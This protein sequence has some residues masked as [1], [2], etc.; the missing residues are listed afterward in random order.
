MKKKILIPVIAGVLIIIGVVLFLILRSGEDSYF[1]IRILYSEGN[2]NIKRDGNSFKASKDMTL[3]DKDYVTVGSDGF[4]RIDCD[5]KTYAHFEHDTEAT[6]KANSNKKLTINMVKG[7]LVIDVQKK[8]DD[9]EKLNIVTPNTTMAIRG[10]VVAVRTYPTEDGG[11]RTINYCLEGKAVVETDKGSETIKA[12]EGWLTVT[13]TEGNITDYTPI[14]AEDLEF[15]G[16]DM[17]SLKGADSEPMKINNKVSSIDTRDLSEVE[18]NGTNFPD[19]IFRL[20]VMD[21]LDLDGNGKLSGDELN[22]KYISIRSSGIKD[23]KGIEYFKELTNL[24]CSSNELA[25]LD[26]SRNTDLKS[27]DCGE[28]LLSELDV[29]NN[30]QLERL[31]CHL[32]PMFGLDVSKNTKLT[33]LYCYFDQLNELDVS[34][35]TA[36]ECLYCG[37]NQIHKIDVSKNT[38]LIELSCYN[39]SISGIDVSKNTK[40]T[41]L[42]CSSNNIATLDVSSNTELENLDCSFTDISDLDLSHNKKLKSF[43]CLYTELTETDLTNNPLLTD[44]NIIYDTGKNHLIR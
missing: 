29:S 26:L 41:M 5:R 2:V 19:T 24:D 43:N 28:N 38:A 33:A 40:L 25:S 14:G 13:D 27:L 12:G 20:Y 9:D 3:R 34:A 4:T 18:I 10:T 6:I 17:D 44:A 32:N 1:N 15:D 30:L 11:T 21:N 37:A 31:D 23:L 35:N 7:E 22:I 36:L 42:N 16:I 8:L 39:T